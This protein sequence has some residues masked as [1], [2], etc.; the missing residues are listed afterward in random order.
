MIRIFQSDN[1]PN[2]ATALAA[3]MEDCKDVF[4]PH[5][6]VADH[7]ASQQWL[8]EFVANANGIV[9]HLHAKTLDG[10]WD[11]IHNVLEAGPTKAEMMRQ[12]QLAWIIDGV[13]ASDSFENDK[14]A[15]AVKEYAEGDALK[16]FGLAEKLAELFVRYQLLD[17]DILEGDANSDKSG[18]GW[19]RLVWK[20]VKERAGDKIPDRNAVFHDAGWMTL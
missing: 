1:Y 2:L 5:F 10:F 15:K 9:A 14:D 6:V 8:R 20:N 13:L 17:P 12:E 18:I 11:M 7:H 4:A 3:T 19:Q 16:R